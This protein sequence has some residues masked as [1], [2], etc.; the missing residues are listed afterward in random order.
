MTTCLLLNSGLKRSFWGEAL[1]TANRLLNS[2]LASTDKNKTPMEVLNG[3]K[4][5]ARSFRVFGCLAIAHI[6]KT[7]RSK[8]DPKAEKCIFVGYQE[9]QK[10][11]RL[12]NMSTRKIIISRDVT[13]IE[14]NFPA[15]ETQHFKTESRQAEENDVVF[16]GQNV[17]T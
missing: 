9:T 13:F 2:T 14:D 3:T 17:K 15:K 10:A 4:P 11:Y 7:Q 5:N 8:F 12:Y 1:L 16:F 6:P